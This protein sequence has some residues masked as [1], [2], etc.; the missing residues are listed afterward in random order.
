MGSPQIA[1]HNF[2]PGPPPPPSSSSSSSS[3]PS[4]QSSS[5]SSS[6]SSPS[7][8]SSS[9]SSSS[10]APRDLPEPKVVHPGI[11]NPK[12]APK[13][14]VCY[15]E[16]KYKAINTKNNYEVCKRC[17]TE[18]V[19]AGIA[20]LNKTGVSIIKNVASEFFA[21]KGVVDPRRTNNYPSSAEVNFVYDVPEK[22]CHVEDYSGQ[23][24]ICVTDT[25]KSKPATLWLYRGFSLPA[26]FAVNNAL[27]YEDKGE[28]NPNS[29]AVQS[30]GNATS[31]GGD[32]LMGSGTQEESLQ[33]D[34]E[35]YLFINTKRAYEEYYLKNKQAMAE[36]LEAS[37]R[38]GLPC[39]V[40][41]W[42]KTGIFSR[43]VY[44]SGVGLR[45]DGLCDSNGATINIIT[46][47]AADYNFTHDG[48]YMGPKE[49]SDRTLTSYRKQLIT[50]WDTILRI[51]YT[52]GNRNIVLTTGGG[53]AYKGD[54][55]EII[56]ALFTVL[57]QHGPRGG[58]C[59]A[60]CFDNIIFASG[61][62]HV[63]TNLCKHYEDIFGKSYLRRI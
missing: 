12:I 33:F 62:G 51:A 29:T 21:S 4:S 61:S 13:G 50:Y 48:T 14:M 31:P 54:N 41:A 44:S 53:G 58:I 36:Q 8:Q 46:T 19:D 17:L 16:C 6:S 63:E 25:S 52:N 28:L 47:A 57:T 42:N 39:S 9:S 34:S 38:M 49:D 56:S 26:I 10:S 60:R 32:A 7:S 5:S 2:K 30:A 45:N 24:P 27:K 37:K 35:A 1:S 59:W 22:Y 40:D 3:N 15:D 55:A 43:G 23:K 11:I 20:R 18:N